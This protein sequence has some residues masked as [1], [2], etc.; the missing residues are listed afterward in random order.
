MVDGCLKN[1]QK[2]EKMAEII[3]DLLLAIQIPQPID[4]PKNQMELQ[5]IS[6]NTLGN[7]PAN[8][9]D[10]IQPE[11]DKK[12]LF[13]YAKNPKGFLLL[14]GKNGI[15]KSYAAEAIYNM[16][17]PYRLPKHDSDKSIFITEMDLYSEWLRSFQ[18]QRSVGKDYNNTLLLV[19]DDF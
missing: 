9:K 16:N 12:D 1:L 6:N 17:T 3:K 18:D 15:G 2:R 7:I 14:A 13:A 8:F 10:L 11:E 5:S 19:I 4:K